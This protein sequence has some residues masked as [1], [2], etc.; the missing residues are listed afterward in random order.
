M[1]LS[2]FVRSFSILAPFF[3]R[4]FRLVSPPIL[5][6]SRV[7]CY[8]LT[9]GKKIARLVISRVKPSPRIQISPS[10]PFLFFCC[11]QKIK[12]ATN[13]AEVKLV[14][15]AVIREIV[16][17]ECIPLASRRIPLIHD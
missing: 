9:R 1:F 11:L 4:N 6:I 3:T 14:I 13:L 17:V 16:V 15:N 10:P 8:T 7:N 5:N 12:S 2:T